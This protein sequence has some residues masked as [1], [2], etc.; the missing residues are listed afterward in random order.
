M[1]GDKDMSLALLSSGLGSLH[2]SFAPDRVSGAAQLIAAQEAAQK[3]KRGMWQNFDPA[4]A[5]AEDTAALAASSAVNVYTVTHVVSGAA[6]QF[7]SPRVMFHLSP[8]LR[9]PQVLPHMR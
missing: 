4:A 5:E 2:P 3:G 8:W 6:L 7:L 9:R 1:V